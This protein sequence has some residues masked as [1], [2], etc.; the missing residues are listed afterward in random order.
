MLCNLIITTVK[1][2][3][4]CNGS[5]TNPTV[6]FDYSRNMYPY[7][8]Y[9]QIIRQ[10]KWADTATPPGAFRFIDT[11]LSISCSGQFQLMFCCC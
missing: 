9:T 11:S 1:L 8:P 10:Q 7:K 6:N 3:Y 2:S 5:S 4:N